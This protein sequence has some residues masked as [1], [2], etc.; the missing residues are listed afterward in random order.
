MFPHHDFQSYTGEEDVCLFCRNYITHSFNEA[1]VCL[2][3]FHFSQPL[4]KQA[5][6]CKYLLYLCHS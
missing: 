6:N 5:S 1:L 3:L 2:L 4:L